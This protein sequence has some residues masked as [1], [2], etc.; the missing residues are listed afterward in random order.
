M[1]FF[2]K[3][4][5]NLGSDKKNKDPE[6]QNSY[7]DSPNIEEYEGSPRYQAYK[8][9]RLEEFKQRENEKKDAEYQKRQKMFEIFK[10]I[11]EKDE[12]DILD[13]FHQITQPLD[14]MKIELEEKIKSSKKIWM[15]DEEKLDLKICLNSVKGIFIG[16]ETSD[17]KELISRVIVYEDEDEDEIEESEYQ[18]EN[19]F[20]IFESFDS[21]RNEKAVNEIG[22]YK[23]YIQV[24]YEMNKPMV[25]YL[26][27]SFGINEHPLDV[28]KF[29][30]DQIY[31]NYGREEENIDK[32]IKIRWESYLKAFFYNRDDINKAAKLLLKFHAERSKTLN[33]EE[34]KRKVIEL[35][36]LEAKGYV[37]LI[38]N[39]DI[40]KIGI[41]DNL[42][43]R[44]NQLK[45]D[46][47]LNVVRCSNY[48]SL[49]KE[50]HKKF[51]EYRIPQTE[52][53]RL[54]D[55]YIEEVNIEMTKGAV[56]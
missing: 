32:W 22:I 40:Y 35:E 54:N 34:P 4:S 19:C 41:T 31:W 52:Y 47:I 39:K 51:K 37:Y 36:N 28:M 29:Y 43:R 53:F 1:N 45:P 7:K 6:I 2:K 25:G 21:W 55:N 14:D 56:F 17:L 10:D 30:K 50:L 5:D 24:Q 44:F 13:F 49:E 15:S 23:K 18:F 9:G 8:A 38:R 16:M 33:G 3:F 42:L 12:D 26:W 48:V 27:N 20:P 46:E 11:Y